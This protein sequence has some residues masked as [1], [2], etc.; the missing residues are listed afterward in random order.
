MRRRTPEWQENEDGEK[1][2]SGSSE[3]FVKNGNEP[4]AGECLVVQHL[5]CSEV[6]LII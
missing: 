4:F 6:L 2:E 3:I 1:Q 5:E